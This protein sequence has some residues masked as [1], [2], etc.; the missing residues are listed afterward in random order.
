MRRRRFQQALLGAG[1]TLLPISGAPAQPKS[2]LR[3][4]ALSA[5]GKRA[6]R[7]TGFPALFERLAELGYVEGRNLEVEFDATGTDP[8]GFYTGFIRRGGDIIFVQGTDLPLG[9]A[10]IATEGRVPIVVLATDYDP[11]EAGYVKSLARPE[12]NIT[13]LFVRQ[14]ELAAKRVELAHAAFPSSRRVIVIVDAVVPQQTEAVTRAGRLLGLDVQPIEDNLGADWALR[15]LQ[16]AGTAPVIA[17]SSH[18]ARVDREKICRAALERRLPLIAPLRAFV[19]AGALLSYGV[20]LDDAYRQAADY[21]YRIAS[22]GKPADLPIEQPT[23]FELVVNLRT[24]KMLGLDL[25]QAF[26]GRADEV[27]E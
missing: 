19:E 5:G 3:I 4:A 6:D 10:R 18:F 7:V 15:R 16:D 8:I 17:P 13:G 24:A 23:G 22:G 25:P 14:P 20:K 11:V 21:I 1:L 27:I 26:L 9:A 12:G 2:K